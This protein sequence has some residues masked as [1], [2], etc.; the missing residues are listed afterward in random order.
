[1]EIKWIQ[2][3]V[4]TAK[5]ENFRKAADELFLTQPAVTKH[6]KRLEEYLAISLFERVGNKVVLTP[7][8]YEFLKIAREIVSTYEQGMKNFESWKQGFNRKLI[9]AVA[10]QIASSFLP[11]LLRSF[12]DQN[13]MIEVIINVITSYEMG[14]EIGSG[15]ADLGLSRV[16][17]T[18]ANLKCERIHEEPVLFVG[19]KECLVSGIMEEEKILQKYRL[20]TYNH[21]DYWDELLKQVKRSYPTVQTMTV[22]Q[23]EVSKRFIEQGLGVS[24]LPKTMVEEEIAIQKMIELTPKKI[25]P[26]KSSTYVLSK[27]ETAEAKFFIRFMQE[28][29]SKKN[30]N[31]GLQF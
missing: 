3:F 24:F 25:I 22:N 4:I 17:P 1:M 12:I 28:A 21:P 19:P 6:I 7:A 10:P 13:P 30:E 31:S 14:E 2:T 27:I 23:V 26:P 9:I 20:L 8:G 16:L 15:R 29:I 18:Q 11:S 5:Y